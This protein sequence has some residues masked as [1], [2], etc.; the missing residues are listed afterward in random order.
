MVERPTKETMD[1]QKNLTEIRPADLPAPPQAALQVLRACSLQQID[2][3]VLAGYAEM[4][5]VLTAEILRVVNSPL[6]GIGKEVTS[7]RNAT[8]LLGA[9]TLRNIVLCLMVREA[10]QDYV[11]DEFNISAFWEDSLRRAVIARHLAENLGMDGDDA[12]TCGIIQ[13]FGLL[14]LYYLHPDVE[15]HFDELRRLSPNARYIR[16]QQLF[17]MTHEQVIAHLADNWALPADLVS[18]VVLHHDNQ[19]TSVKMA[20]VLQCADWMCTVFSSQDINQAMQRSINLAMQKL[21]LNDKQV[22]EILIQLPAEVEASAHAMGLHICEQVDFEKL[23]RQANSL[24]A[25]ENLSYQELNWQLEKAIAER[26]KL[27][28]EL[29]QEIAI[30]QEVQGKFMPERNPELPVA[31]INLPARVISGDFYDYLQLKDGRIWFA[32]GDVSG[33]GINAGLLMSKTASLFRCLARR[34]DDPQKLM[35]ILNAEICETATRGFFVSMVAGIYSPADRSVQLVNAGHLPV[36]IEH[37]D[38]RISKIEACAQPLG[39][40]PQTSY[41]ASEVISLQ[42]SALYLYS[43]G[44]TE[45]P[46]GKEDS[47]GMLQEKG[48]IKL[49]QQYRALPAMQRVQA[50]VNVLKAMNAATGKALHDDITLLLLEPA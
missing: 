4:D 35:Q 36:I 27:A 5:P 26:D 48:F 25:Q 50:I 44:V 12:F 16:E 37:P 3:R 29:E 39:I 47:E 9:H 14:V 7:V 13:D 19:Q 42:N 6:F 38:Q 2:N 33:K 11:I 31:A 21:S 20:G 40:L 24:L 45:A 18:A 41:P 28:A 30:A 17:S 32:L 43:D 46:L 1:P 15:E 23:L 8:A 49:F 22:R 10:A 34:M